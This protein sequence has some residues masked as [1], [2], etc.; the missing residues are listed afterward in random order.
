MKKV[1]DNASLVATF[2]SRTQ[3][4]GRN[5]TGSIFFDGNII[6]SYGRHFPIAK[7]VG[8]TIL[9]TTRSW[10]V[11][12]ARHVSMVHSAAYGT[13]LDI[14]TVHDPLA[15]SI[16]EISENVR[17]LNESIDE[18][19]GKAARARKYADMH[20]DSVNRQTVN[21]INYE[22]FVANIVANAA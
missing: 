2:V 9:I 12:T 10:S 13:T 17:L 19:K 18:S 16:R 22:T 14:I 3:S 1:F 4:E 5:S 6:Y 8:N 21:R 7:I 20:N 11:T 15:A